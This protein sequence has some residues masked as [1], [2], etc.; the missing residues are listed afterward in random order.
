M[1]VGAFP[2]AC[3][4]QLASTGN[5]RQI[6]GLRVLPKSFV[7]ACLSHELMV[8]VVTRREGADESEFVRW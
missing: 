1:R 7:T 4:G 2:P 3:R 8:S 6:D 5:R